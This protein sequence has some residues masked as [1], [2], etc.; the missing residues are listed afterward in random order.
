MSMVV[1]KTK[2][3]VRAITPNHVIQVWLDAEQNALCVELIN[4]N[5]EL[6]YN[7]GK[8]LFG[9]DFPNEMNWSDVDD[10]EFS[11][12]DVFH[13]LTGG[14]YSRKINDYFNSLL[15]NKS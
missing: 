4:G 8:T 11:A 2:T 6:F 10:A 15:G 12:I 14:G 5:K 13:Q 3:G 1:I 7:G 9:I